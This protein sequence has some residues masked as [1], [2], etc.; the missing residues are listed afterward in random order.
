[1][2]NSDTEEM[3]EALE[4]ENATMKEYLQKLQEENDRLV[5]DALSGRKVKQSK[6]E[7]NRAAEIG[8]NLSFVYS[9]KLIELMIY[10]NNKAHKNLMTEEGKES[11][12]ALKSHALTEYANS[13]LDEILLHINEA[14]KTVGSKEFKR[15][16]TNSLKKP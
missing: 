4:L 15:A 8:A 2:T 1:M 10:S 6:K 16:V 9:I 3:I 14:I 7:I 13:L 11:Q 5:A 12:S